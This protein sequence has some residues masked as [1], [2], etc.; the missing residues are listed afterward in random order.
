LIIYPRLVVTSNGKTVFLF[1]LTLFN[2]SR[3]TLLF[4]VKYFVLIFSKISILN[5]ASANVVLESSKLSWLS[6]WM[7]ELKCL[8]ASSFSLILRPLET[9]KRMLVSITLGWINFRAFKS[10]SNECPIRIE[11]FVNILK[12]FY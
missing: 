7:R 1:S 11:F 2:K 6:C 8:A 4:S 3:C 10:F 9:E 5:Y 12:S